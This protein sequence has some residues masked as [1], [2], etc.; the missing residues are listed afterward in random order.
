VKYSRLGLAGLLLL[1]L[2][3]PSCEWDGH[4]TLFGYT[5]RPNYDPQYKTV[6][7]NIFK[8][9]TFWAVVPVPGLEMELTRAIIREI[10]AKTPYKVVREN[11]DTE[12]VGKVKSFTQGILSYNQL[13]ERREVETNLLAE[14]AWRDLRT[15]KLLTAP[16]RFPGM[17]LP[18][19]ALP[20]PPA[21]NEDVAGRVLAPIPATPTSPLNQGTTVAPNIPSADQ[22]PAIQPPPDL[23]IPPI[24]F[25]LVRSIGHYRPELGE[26][27]ST[28]QKENVDRM[29][30]S[31]VFMMESPW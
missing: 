20:S 27:I 23:P 9:P 14:V 5:T 6:K 28:A 7:V 17:P 11:A 2:L 22:A 15:G 26:S 10:E 13:Y 4:L 19:E 8:N 12:L 24:A 25:Q 29:A 18:E 1:V 3:V 16:R 31:I 30:T 21:L